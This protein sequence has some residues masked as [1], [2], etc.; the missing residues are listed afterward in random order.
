[1]VQ[2]GNIRTLI[3]NS[4]EDYNIYD[5]SL[6]VSIISKVALEIW[7]ILGTTGKISVTF[8][9][10]SQIKQTHF[11]FLEY[12]SI[13]RQVSHWQYHIKFWFFFN[14]THLQDEFDSLGSLKK[15]RNKKLFISTIALAFLILAAIL[16]TIFLLT[17]NNSPR[18]T[19]DRFV[20]FPLGIYI[21]F[22]NIESPN[23]QKKRLKT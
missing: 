12:S 2:C 6:N 14:F 18:A 21:S 23:F 17:R 19:Y 22:K 13:F 16:I 4:E 15:P 7:E 11:I 8:L 3:C 9:V 5:V 10:I 20:C 1:M